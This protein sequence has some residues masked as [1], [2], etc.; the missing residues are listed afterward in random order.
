VCLGS[1][2]AFLLLE[3]TFE[4]LTIADCERVFD[5]LESRSAL[6][7]EPRIFARSKL[8]LLRMCN[9]VLRRL[10][11]APT[12]LLVHSTHRACEVLVCAAT[13]AP[14]FGL[15]LLESQASNTEFCGRVLVFLASAFPLSERSAV[16]VKSLYNTGNATE[17]EATRA[18][19]GGEFRGG[20]DPE[21]E[22]RLAEARMET[23]PSLRGPGGGMGA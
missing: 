20:R 16:N 7:L 5:F 3:E 4:S 2:I 1:Q 14:S 11:K 6:L 13:S 15:T 21:V 22:A 19:P 17:F 8:V 9:E 23:G 18:S 10:S 12:T